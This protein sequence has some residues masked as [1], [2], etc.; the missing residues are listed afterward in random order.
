[1]GACLRC[2]SAGGAMARCISGQEKARCD[3]GT[4]VLSAAEGS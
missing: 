2:G 4:V 3:R 1:M